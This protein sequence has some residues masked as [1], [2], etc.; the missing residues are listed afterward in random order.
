MGS[1]DN[2]LEKFS[3]L[4]EPRKLPRILKREMEIKDIKEK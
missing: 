1:L 2:K 4:K 3:E